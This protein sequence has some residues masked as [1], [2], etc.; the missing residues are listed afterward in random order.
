MR[1]LRGA[2]GWPGAD[3]WARRA[4]GIAPTI[5]GGSKKHGGADLG[6]PR[7]QRAWAARGGGGRSVQG[8]VSVGGRSQPQTAFVWDPIDRLTAPLTD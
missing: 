2:R 3:R 6:P 5:V 4:D 7:A 8:R 1:D